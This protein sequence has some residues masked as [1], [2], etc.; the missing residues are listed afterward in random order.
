MKMIGIVCNGCRQTLLDS[1]DKCIHCG[2][3][4]APDQLN[5]AKWQRY[6]RMDLLKK[7]DRNCGPNAT[8]EQKAHLAVL[9]L[10]LKTATF[11]GERTE[12]DRCIYRNLP[13]NG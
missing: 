13:F 9:E 8:F 11:K 12:L 6:E 10:A 7:E 1:G 4:F 5:A 3:P 2:H